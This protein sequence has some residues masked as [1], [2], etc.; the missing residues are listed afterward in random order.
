MRSR[1]I[2]VG[3][4]G[5][6][7]FVEVVIAVVEGVVTARDQWREEVFRLLWCWLEIEL[8]EDASQNSNMP[9]S[10]QVL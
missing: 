8:V 4:V 3:E 5:A 7:G 6:V 9:E 2:Q 10:R 1:D